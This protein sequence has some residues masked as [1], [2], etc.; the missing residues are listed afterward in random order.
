METR[1]KLKA[2]DFVF[3]FI[4]FFL[5]NASA[6]VYPFWLFPRIV[7]FQDV[8]WL[9]VLVL[10]LWLLYKQSLLN[11]FVS[12]VAEFLA[13]LPFLLFAGLTFF[14]S[15]EKTITLGRWLIF[16]GVIAC[17]GYVGTKYT[18]RQFLR[19]LS[20]FGVFILFLNGL[21]VFVFPRVGIMNYYIIQDA[22]KGLYWHKN[23]LGLIASLIN[24]LCL[25][26]F[27]DTYQRQGVERIIWLL[28]FLMSFAFIVKSDSAAALMSSLLMYGL[29]FVLLLWTKWRK[30]L[31]LVHYLLFLLAVFV[32]MAGLFSR[33]DTVLSIF[34]RNS[35][36]TG[37]VP[38][39]GF[40][41]E[42]YFSQRPYFGYGFNA[43]WYVE[44]HRVS[45]Q[46]AAG[47][48]DPIV[49]ADNGFIDLLLNN[50]W[51]GFVLFLIF[52]FNLWWRAY[53]FAVKTRGVISIFP[54]LTMIFVL[55]A[56]ITWSVLFENESF[57]M[58]IMVCIAILLP[59]ELDRER[60]LLFDTNR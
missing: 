29:I 39:W 22:W 2:F 41:Y 26:E 47:Y 52:Y 56:N 4:L 40:L 51:V 18:L 59:R 45:A 7:F 10:L 16:I 21:I 32:A 60:D 36:L 49:I 20:I 8:L 13:L 48:P 9:L 23:H 38:M 24:F 5:S 28:T 58:L 35:T 1:Y 42:E 11:D 46:V 43:F 19:M 34:N 27:F 14:W 6:F 57:F 33:L 31:T 12:A 53:T 37:R 55:L 30:K 44:T 3:V 54:L 25:M 17:G 15:V 50:G